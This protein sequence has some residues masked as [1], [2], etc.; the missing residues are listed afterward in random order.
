MASAI[1]DTVHEAVNSASTDK[2]WYKTKAAEIVNDI[3]AAGLDVLFKDAIDEA[4]EEINKREDISI[5]KANIAKL[6][7]LMYGA[8][9]GVLVARSGVEVTSDRVKARDLEVLENYLF[10]R[11]RVMIYRNGALNDKLG[12]GEI[13]NMLPGAIYLFGEAEREDI[14]SKVRDRIAKEPE[15]KQWLLKFQFVEAVKKSRSRV[16]WDEMKSELR[17][18]KDAFEAYMANNHLDENKL[19]PELSV[20]WANYLEVMYPNREGEITRAWRSIDARIRNENDQE[21]KKRLLLMV[22]S[23]SLG[24]NS[25]IR[26]LGDISNI[27]K[28]SRNPYV[29]RNLE[30]LSGEVAE[31]AEINIKAI[32]FKGDKPYMTS[33]RMEKDDV[34]TINFAIADLLNSLPSLSEP[35]TLKDMVEKSSGKS[36]MLVR[37][38]LTA[39]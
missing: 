4:M 1:S 9:A 29:R 8:A 30:M 38:V 25:N 22:F 15:D 13:L 5:Q 33:N 3:H 34:D 35:K 2:E 32:V 26:S 14:L 36:F 10:E 24:E 7:A 18:M 37:K 39:A 19:A 23:I 16:L 27:I 20:Y 12:I 28:S 11:A 17:D 21:N 31:Q 6:G